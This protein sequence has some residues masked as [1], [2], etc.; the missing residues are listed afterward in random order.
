MTPCIAIFD[1]GVPV[2][3]ALLVSVLL[4]FGRRLPDVARYLGKCFFDF[5][6]GRQGPEDEC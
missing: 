2:L 3:V 5:K 1:L 4:L 6:N